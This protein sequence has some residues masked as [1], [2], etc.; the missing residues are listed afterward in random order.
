MVLA[1]MIP[2]TTDAWIGWMLAAIVISALILPRG[3]R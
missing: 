1:F 3:A 2:A